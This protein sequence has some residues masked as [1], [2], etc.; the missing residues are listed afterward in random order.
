MDI[1]CFN[2]Y[3][4]WYTEPGRLETIT[5]AV[6]SE[7]EN[8]HTKYKKPVIMAEYGAEAMEGLHIVCKS[9]ILLYLNTFKLTLIV[10]K[11]NYNF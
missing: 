3:N 5:R 10:N 4:A 11:Q 8:W 6:V 2:R 1:I 7:A 9:Y